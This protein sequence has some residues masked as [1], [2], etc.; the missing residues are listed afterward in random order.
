MLI[1]DKVTVFQRWLYIKRG[2]PRLACKIT[3]AQQY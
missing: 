1:Q 2:G 3:L